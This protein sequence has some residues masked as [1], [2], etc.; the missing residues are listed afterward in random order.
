MRRIAIASALLVL[1]CLFA[2]PPSLSSFPTRAG[3]VWSQDCCGKPIVR[4]EPKYPEAAAR[5]GQ[6]GWVIVSGILDQRGWVI[7]PVVLAS[8]PKGVF[9]DA[10]VAAFDSWRYATPP[11]DAAAPREVRELL[12]FERRRAP[13]QIPSDTGGGG[14]GGGQPG[15]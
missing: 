3:A 7:D 5:S 8:D 14:G 9:D 13:G 10:A 6:T 15:Y 12:R 11:T 1:G 2:A 4:Q